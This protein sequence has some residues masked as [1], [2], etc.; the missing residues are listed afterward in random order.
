VSD[1]VSTE[2]GAVWLSPQILRWRTEEVGWSPATS[3]LG[4]MA[5]E[6]WDHGFLRLNPPRQDSLDRKED[7][8]DAIA[9]LWRA[10]ERRIQLFDEVYNIRKVLRI[11]S[12]ESVRLAHLQELGL[13]RGSVLNDIRALRNDIQ[14]SRR[15]RQGTAVMREAAEPPS[16]DQCLL[17]QDA[18]WYFLR[19]TERFARRVPSEYAFVGESLERSDN[20]VSIEMEP[21]EWTAGVR[22]DGISVDLVS[23]IPVESWIPIKLVFTEEL[24]WY[25]YSMRGLV[26]MSG[27]IEDAAWT[28]ELAKMYFATI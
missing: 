12:R 19:S 26:L 20:R 9:A 23:R 5:V 4:Q 24:G 28:L 27:Y 7:R 6:E 2:D 8:K 1:E 3:R 22:A 18:V 16:R 13:V 11:S 14:H 25:F 21:P 17:Y 15:V 10:V